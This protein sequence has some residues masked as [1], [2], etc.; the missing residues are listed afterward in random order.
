MAPSSRDSTDAGR[1]KPSSVSMAKR[2]ARSGPSR[3]PAARR[4]V[5]ARARIADPVVRMWFLSVLMPAVLGLTL[6]PVFCALSLGSEITT[7][8]SRMSWGHGGGARR[9]G[10][11]R[12][13]AVVVRARGWR[14]WG[15]WAPGRCGRRARPRGAAV[16][17][18]ST[19]MRGAA[20]PFAQILE[21][22]TRPWRECMAARQASMRVTRQTP[23]K[24]WPAARRRPGSGWPARAPTT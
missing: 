4:T 2:A 21:A 19:V 9:G 8:A 15:R 1:S 20:P 14:W 22:P 13:M 10:A 23:S 12:S 3:A 7:S 5:A 6:S 16:Q 17:M 18:R 24:R 11:R